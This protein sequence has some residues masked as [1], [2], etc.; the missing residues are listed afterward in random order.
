MG[1]RW[2]WE[3]EKETRERESERRGEEEW[4]ERERKESRGRE[5]KVWGGSSSE[6]LAGYANGE[7]YEDSRTVGVERGEREGERER[8]GVG[9]E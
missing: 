8:E 5:E 4:R 3:W 2:G 1:G 7:W 6:K 9:R